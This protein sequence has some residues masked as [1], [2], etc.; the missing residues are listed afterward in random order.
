[1]SRR[2]YRKWWVAHQTP[3]PIAI[4]QS[5]FTN[6]RSRARGIKVTRAHAQGRF[7]REQ[8]TQPVIGTEILKRRGASRFVLSTNDTIRCRRYSS[9]D[10]GR[11]AVNVSRVH[12]RKGLLCLQ[13]RGNRFATRYAA[14]G[15]A[16]PRRL[17]TRLTSWR[18]AETRRDIARGD[19][20][21]IRSAVR[22]AGKFSL[23]SNPGPRLF[24]QKKQNKQDATSKVGR[25]YIYQP[26][27]KKTSSQKKASL[28][29]QKSR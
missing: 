18:S 4:R 10:D 1:M 6:T 24:P 23:L 12:R 16:T 7:M 11:R 3:T 21:W 27:E 22:V 14:S 28:P 26:P 2:I 15:R 17:H 13:T 20:G 29:L 25:V 9:I 19:H 5:G 8:W